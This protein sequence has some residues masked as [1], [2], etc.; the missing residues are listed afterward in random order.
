MN[1]EKGN[2]YTGNSQE[3]EYVFRAKGRIIYDPAPVNG[4]GGKID[5]WCVAIILD[6]NSRELVRYMQYWTKKDHGIVLNDVEYGAHIMLVNKEKPRIGFEGNWKKYHNKLV[7]F[8]YSTILHS[9]ENPQIR[10]TGKEIPPGH[11]WWLP[12]FD[13]PEI[14]EVRES[15]GLSPKPFWSLHL[16]I[17]TAHPKFAGFAE[18]VIRKKFRK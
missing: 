3:S 7:E 8:S 16:T 4:N 15:L 12:V 1:F 18:D 6:A 14:Q 5:P 17:G 9:N 13:C 2:Q 10:K 11:Y